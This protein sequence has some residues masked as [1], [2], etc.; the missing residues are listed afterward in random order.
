MISD[1]GSG[2]CPS[3]SAKK[4]DAWS[5]LVGKKSISDIEI[6][7]IK[8]M[9]ARGMKNK[10]VQ[11]FFNRPDRAV[12]SGRMSQI[13]SG[14]YGPKVA[15]AT[16]AELDAFIATHA[17]ITSLGA[18]QTI[19]GGA[20]SAPVAAP[21]QPLEKSVVSSF[22]NQ[23]AFGRWRLAVGETDRYECKESFSLRYYGKWVKAVAAMANNKGGYIFFGVKDGDSSATAEKDEGYLVVG[24]EKD[25][26][27]QADIAEILRP[28][29]S[30]LDPTPAVHRTTIDIGGLCVGVLHVET[31]PARPVI[32]RGGVDRDLREGDIYFRYPGS[33]E[34][35]KYSDLRAILDDRDTTAR[36]AILPMV[37]RLLSLGPTRALIAD[38]DTGLLEDGKRPILL[39]QALVEQIKFIREG[40]FDE[41][42]GAPALRLVGDVFAD[43]KAVGTKIVRANIT[44]DAVLRNFLMEESVQ[45]PRQYLAHSA[46]ASRDWQPI[47]YY[48]KLAGLSAKEAIKVLEEERASQPVRRTKTIARLKGAQSAYNVSSGR[49]KQ[50]VRAFAA[51]EIEE[52]TD[53]DMAK[54]FAL[55]L[56][57][58]SD[59][60]EQ[61]DKLRTL[62]MG[63][64]ELAAPGSTAHTKLSSAVFR[65]A[66]RLDELL[67]KPVP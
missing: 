14:S 43:G 11:F 42:E 51:G 45:E 5:R 64:Y 66:C 8:A 17:P 20:V 27:R 56:Q 44:S 21:L 22:F 26:F 12:N 46:H 28:I 25:D 3:M 38:L 59:G 61:L 34:R 31:H 60:Q 9:L 49:A 67:Y 7:L 6:G 47:W 19:V 39:D 41:K 35:I 33:S 29:K 63:C 62:L 55:A 50:L 37:E 32:V 48:L 58:L 30:M 36:Q 40:Q 52:P 18:I 16:D 54:N 24:L 23:D 57:G 4:V 65:A 15:Q 53:I 1:G 13:R 2:S 10:D